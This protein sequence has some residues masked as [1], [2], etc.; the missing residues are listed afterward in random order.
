MGR[1]GGWRVGDVAMEEMVV[2]NNSN[3]LVF[4]IFISKEKTQSSWGLTVYL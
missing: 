3:R 4:F 2:L 1:E